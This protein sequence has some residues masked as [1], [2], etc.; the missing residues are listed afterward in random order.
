[1]LLVKE[2]E[3]NTVMAP[4]VNWERVWDD[5]GSGKSHDCSLWRGVASDP[6]EYKV[7]GDF[8]R[9]G[10]DNQNPPSTQVVMC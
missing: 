8:F 9:G 5:H 2:I 7:I 6:V 4:V 10:V 3:P 1:M